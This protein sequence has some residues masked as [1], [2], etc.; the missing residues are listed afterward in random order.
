MDFSTINFYCN[1]KSGVE[2]NGNNADI[3][4]TFTLTEPP[5]YLINIIPT[6]DRM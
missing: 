1:S 6:N 3:I 4:Y 5:G 2:D